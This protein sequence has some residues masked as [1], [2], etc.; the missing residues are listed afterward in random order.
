MRIQ[1]DF[2]CWLVV[3]CLSV[4][5]LNSW[6]EEKY[7]LLVGCTVYPNLEERFHLRGPANDV[8]LARDLLTERFGFE[9]TNIVTLVDS[10]D[11]ISHSPTRANIEREWI[12]LADK[13]A[14]GDQVFVLMAGHGTQAPVTELL[15]NPEPDGLDE[16]FLP[17]DVGPWEDSIKEVS[18][19]IKDDEI[20]KW[21]AGIQGKGAHLWIMID[22]CHSGT[23]TRNLGDEIKRELSPVALGIPV[24]TGTTS[25]STGSETESQLFQ[26]T[27]QTRAIN[28][29]ENSGPVLVALY[30][31]QSIEPTVEKRFP[32]RGDNRKYYGLLTY[33]MNEIL[34]QTEGA[35]TYRE[36]VQQIHRKYV[37]MGRVS[38]TPVLEGNGADR[39]VLGL[40]RL[41]KPPMMSLTGSRF[42]GYRI[43]GGSLN[44]LTVGSILSLHVSA[45]EEKSET[46]LGYLKVLE[47]EFQASSACVEPIE[48]DGLEKPKLKSGLRCKAKFVDFGE[49]KLALA[50]A[51][52]TEAGEQI[53]ADQKDRLTA[54]L[55]RYVTGHQ[56]LTR[57]VTDESD[58]TLLLTIKSLRSPVRVLSPVDGSQSRGKDRP[59]LFG[60]APL[61][62]DNFSD[63]LDESISRIARVK[64]LLAITGG[65]AGQAW[66]DDGSLEVEIR[67]YRSRSDRIGKLIEFGSSG[68][69]LYAGNRI[70]FTVKNT[71]ENPLDVTMLMIDSGYGIAPIY[72]ARGHVNRLFPGNKIVRTGTV[73]EDTL[74]VEHLLVIAN[75]AKPVDEPTN[76]SFLAQKTI[77]QTRAVGNDAVNSALGN[78]F[79]S[80]LFGQG[81]T[82]GAASSDIDTY[83]LRTLTWRTMPSETASDVR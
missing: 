82:R 33:T 30:A 9:S 11:D 48:Y 75:K 63:W 69:R 46:P 67:I 35:L 24:E 70:G 54:V 2:R 72:P 50:V 64:Q 80:A 34:T 83:V 38:P 81:K 27:E 4:S 74:G 79:R 25:G 23:M 28:A 55:N 13:A 49:N 43:D 32:L 21:I 68:I 10:P 17:R 51:Q 52:E 29:S 22:A 44:G 12:A 53:P 61:E 45:G 41:P 71:S 77:S 6:A 42:R 15:D 7:A 37:T 36:L 31:A 57:V 66:K 39:E 16:M 62:E 14:K 19:G 78:V 73:T 65:P 18:N 3:A 56:H 1:S 5:S 40:N 20:K 76:F 58:A 47:K 60:P 26:K 59:P 8:V